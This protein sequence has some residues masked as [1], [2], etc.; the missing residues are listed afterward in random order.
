MR[1]HALAL[2]VAPLLLSGCGDSTPTLRDGVAAIGR[3]WSGDR[4]ADGKP[5]LLRGCPDVQGHFSLMAEAERGGQFHL[6]T[7]LLAGG[8]RHDPGHPWRSVRIEG[9]AG[10]EL[11]LTYMR[12]GTGEA[13]RDSSAGLPAHLR[14]ALETPIAPGFDTRS[15]VLRAG[16]HYDCKGGWL[17]P[18]Q[19][20]RGAQ[21]RRDH[22]GDLEGRIEV[23]SAR[24]ISLWAET[25]AGIPYWFDT[26]VRS[27]RWEAEGS[28]ATGTDAMAVP[29]RPSGGV[30]RQEW[31]LTYRGA[32]QRAPSA[33]ATGEP[34]YDA[35]SAIRAQIDRNA[36]VE[37]IQREDGRYVV[38]LRVA[39]RGAVLRSLDSLRTDVHL[40]DVQ[41][42][43]VV[44]GG[45][46]PDLATISVRLVARR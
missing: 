10:R 32:E 21:I 8:V 37:S 15:V 25:G 20:Q 26:T 40:T 1:P 30:A 43:G 5:V 38:R 14:Y 11:L 12:P 39:S 28:L 31:D 35:D 3:W 13:R 2:V 44:S 6:L 9:H 41:D 4:V 16:E 27:A 23:R 42:H 34:P 19:G 29:P 7:T 24:V 46:R 33:G 45:N 22:R 36:T 18:A 17:V